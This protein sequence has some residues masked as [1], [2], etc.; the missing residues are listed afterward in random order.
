ME[1]SSNQKTCSKDIL[2]KVKDILNK[3]WSYENYFTHTG[4]DSNL[5]GCEK[6]NEWYVG[7]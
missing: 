2:E 7:G 4:N 6:I 3:E 5:W 1:R